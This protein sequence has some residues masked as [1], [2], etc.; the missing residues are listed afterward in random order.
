MEVTIKPVDKKNWKDI[1]KLKV[2]DSQAGFVASNIYSLAEAAYGES[3]VPLGI[4]HHNQA[5]GFIM[6]ES[7]DY[8][9]KEGEY[10][11]FRFMVDKDHQNKGVG[12][13]AL[14]R[15]VADISSM[16]N[17]KR[18]TICYLP[19]NS[20]AKSFYQSIG[21]SEVGLDESGEMIAEIKNK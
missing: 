3:S 8:E 13:L 21:F 10:N 4:F 5:V 20:V 16:P 2:S 6:Y 9:G 1:I 19:N 18:I 17:C 12:R 14:Q 7:L 15:T 11:I